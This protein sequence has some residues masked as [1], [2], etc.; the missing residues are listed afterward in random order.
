MDRPVKISQS[1]K[2]SK[3]NSITRKWE[4]H[5]VVSAKQNHGDR[6]K[7]IKR[8][9]WFNY[10]INGWLTVTDQLRNWLDDNGYS[11]VKKQGE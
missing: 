8:V 11:D 10:I 7:P 5:P 3:W 4:V 9:M 6:M 2:T 1:W